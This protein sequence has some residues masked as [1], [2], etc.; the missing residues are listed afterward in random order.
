[1]GATFRKL[2]G[3]MNKAERRAWRKALA[4]KEWLEDIENYRLKLE[5]EERIE[6]E[7]V[8][9]LITSCS[10]VKLVSFH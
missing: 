8:G 3:R 9:K 7:R 4:E 1:M 2:T 6:Q 10:I 5:K